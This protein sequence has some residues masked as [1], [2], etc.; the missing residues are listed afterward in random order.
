[1]GTKWFVKRGGVEKGPIEAAKLKKLADAGNVLPD[2]EVRRGDQNRWT[3]AANVKGL[4]NLTPPLPAIR[5]PSSCHVTMD[6]SNRQDRSSNAS[7]QGRNAAIACL[8]L[9]Y[10]LLGTGGWLAREYLPLRKIL[11]PPH[12]NLNTEVG[13]LADSWLASSEERVIDGLLTKFLHEVQKQFNAEYEAMPSYLD[14]DDPAVQP[15]GI[16]FGLETKEG[17]QGADQIA[18]SWWNNETNLGHYGIQGGKLCRVRLCYTRHQRK[19][20]DANFSPVDI[21]YNLVFHQ[22]SKS[23]KLVR[24]V[25]PDEIVRSH[26]EGRLVFIRKLGENSVPAEEVPTVW[27]AYLRTIG[28]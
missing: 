1:M 20:L 15:D 27:N 11:F 6:S 14:S 2:D 3:K 4:F 25:L 10:F 23:L 8:V 5:E 9:L 7:A 26:V 28:N 18:K 19:S 22:N 16:L 12:R 24:V 13:S 17:R 21:D